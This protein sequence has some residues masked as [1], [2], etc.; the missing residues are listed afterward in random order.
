M[1]WGY[2]GLLRP[3]AFRAIQPRRGGG[4][5][6]HRRAAQRDS[7]P[8]G[9]QDSDSASPRFMGGQVNSRLFRWTSSRATAYRPGGVLASEIHMRHRAVATAE[10]CASRPGGTQAELLTEV[11]QHESG[12]NLQLVLEEFLNCRRCG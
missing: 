3:S 4:A 12:R 1:P 7:S 5:M 11:N 8:A 6:R 2:S 10:G 9:R